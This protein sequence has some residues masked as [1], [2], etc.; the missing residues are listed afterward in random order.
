[1]FD[2]VT[3]SYLV[4]NGAAKDIIALTFDLERGSRAQENTDVINEVEEYLMSESIPYS[5]VFPIVTR[6]HT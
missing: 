5:Q 2:T 3:V 1:M 4:L 6:V